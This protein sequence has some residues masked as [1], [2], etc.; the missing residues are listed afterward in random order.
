MSPTQTTFWDAVDQIRAER[1]SYRREAYGFV[2]AALGH[3]VEAL[4]AERRADPE[5]R[6]L[7]GQELLRG[8]V[9]LARREFGLMAPTVFREWG[10]HAS[11]DVGE[12]VFQ[13]VEA[14][15]L[16]A[17]G[18][19]RR[20]DFAGGPDLL[21]ALSDGLDLGVPGAHRPSP[22]PGSRP[23]APGGGSGPGGPGPGGSGTTV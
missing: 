21:R 19:D 4:P 23:A 5:R 7:S 11:T 20:E 15:Q 8:A 2:V 16:S 10:L 1:P 6:H 14:G 18:E 9:E 17:R 22:P 13:L 3:T 12:I